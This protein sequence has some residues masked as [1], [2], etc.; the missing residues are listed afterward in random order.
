[1]CN[2]LYYQEQK[3]LFEKLQVYARNFSYLNE[4]ES[5]RTSYLFLFK[6]IKL[7]ITSVEKTGNGL[8]QVKTKCSVVK[9]KV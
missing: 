4:I 2:G 9:V 6:K 7:R 3:S 1:M 8:N 5:Y